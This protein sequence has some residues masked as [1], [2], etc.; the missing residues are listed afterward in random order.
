MVTDD[1]LKLSIAEELFPEPEA[2]DQYFF[3]FKSN[4]PE[5]FDFRTT[6]HSPEQVFVPHHSPHFNLEDGQL[7]F[8]I[9]QQDEVEI[10]NPL[11]DDPDQDDPVE[12]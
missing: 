6:A 2:V 1:R 11:Q 5:A 8:E 4:A 3:D 10:E 12:A 9:P 7:E